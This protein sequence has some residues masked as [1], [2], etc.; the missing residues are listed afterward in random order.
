MDIATSIHTFLSICQGI[1]DFLLGVMAAGKTQRKLRTELD[2]LQG[3]LVELDDAGTS[4]GR[5]FSLSSLNLNMLLL[6]P[7]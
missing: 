5:T 1:H 3:L 4:A 2:A 7:S 6:L